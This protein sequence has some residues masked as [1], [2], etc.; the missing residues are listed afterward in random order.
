MLMIAE[1]TGSALFS[2]KDKDRIEALDEELANVTKHFLNV[3]DVEALSLART[4]GKHSLSQYSVRPF[5]MAL[6]RA[7]ASTRA[8]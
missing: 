7:E 5:L 8:A 3:V 1:R 6:C 2:S 4:A